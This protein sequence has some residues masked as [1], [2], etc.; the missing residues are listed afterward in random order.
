[1]AGRPRLEFLHFEARVR[2]RALPAGLSWRTTTFLFINI[3][4]RM[5]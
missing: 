1:M 4:E 2:S 3:V 5:V